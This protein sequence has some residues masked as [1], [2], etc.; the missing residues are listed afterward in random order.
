[1]S[2]P[3]PTPKGIAHDDEW[4]RMLAESASMAVVIYRDDRILFANSA[5]QEVMGYD[6]AELV[7]MEDPWQVVAPE[8]REE[9]S[10][11]TQA[12]QRGEEVPRHLELKLCHRS[13]EERWVE[14]SAHRIQFDGRSATLAT[15]LDVTTHR[16]AEEA[17]SRD[18]ELVHV[19]LTATG[20]GVIRTDAEGRVDYMNPV[21]EKL[22]GWSLKEARGQSITTLYRGVGEA[23]RR[24]RR[25]PV[26]LCLSE[27][28]TIAPPGLLALYARDG[29]EHT[30][31]D[32]AAPI[33]DPRGNILGAV[34]VIRDLTRVRGLEQQMAY[35]ASHDQVTGLLNRQELEIHLE[36]ALESARDFD[37]HHALLSI[38]T[39]E[40]KLINDC[41]GMVA[42]DEL[43]RQ[44][45][46]LLRREL[47]PRG[48]LGRLAGND[49]GLLLEDLTPDEAGATARD[50]LRRFRSFRFAWAGHH[51]E[52]GLSLGVVPI[53]SRTLGVQQLIKAADASGYLARQA[54][55]NQIHVSRSDEKLLAD[56]HG[57]MHW[58]QRIHRALAEDRFR[59]F[60]QEIRPLRDGLP[61]LH[62]ILIRMVDDDGSFL[63]PGSFIPVAEGHDLA[64]AI[65]RW[66][67]RRTLRLLS[68]VRSGPLTGSAVSINLSAQ[69]L[70]DETFVD[71]LVGAI[72]SSGMAADRL[73]FEITETAAVANLERTLRLTQSL[74]ALGCHLVLDDFGSG[75]SSFSH[76]KNLPVDVLKIDGEFVRSMSQEP[77]HLA[78][79][80]AINDIGHIMGLRT[81]AEWVE[82]ETTLEHL[83][84][85][86]VDY[87]QGYLLHRPE[88]I[89]I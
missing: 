75:F 61:P 41:Y 24:A 16:R 67:V 44:V 68:A 66:V 83:R 19:A 49:F 11:R 47:E 18:Q 32:S 85:I 30:V 39:I 51:F 5:A 89:K 77:I 65:D 73:Y 10:A 69:S 86:D 34:L 54:G 78:M 12:R 4:F 35:L 59:L 81:I 13:G 37:K 63:P 74:K 50:V 45:S 6:P 57:R 20:D 58:V 46:E 26:E 84:A 82:D 15:I 25:N 8:Y 23:S 33:H 14:V 43:L 29:K 9:A 1:M 88:E 36:A 53:T 22:T 56:H 71:D 48:I 79:V 70:G 72:Q 7:A 3:S 76:L 64:P 2:T 21:A 62:E 55:R 27:G 17:M 52:V 28:R 31:K 38:H 60:H 87:V 80:T 40:L 42:G